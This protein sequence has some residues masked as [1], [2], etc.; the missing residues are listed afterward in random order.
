MKQ[1]RNK[2]IYA[3]LLAVLMLLG[4]VMGVYAEE[5]ITG[6]GDWLV[7]IGISEDSIDDYP[8]EDELVPQAATACEESGEAND[9]FDWT[10]HHA[11]IHLSISGYENRPIHGVFY[12]SA[13]NAVFSFKPSGAYKTVDRNNVILYYYHYPNAGIEYRSNVLQDGICETIIVQKNKSS[14]RAIT[15]YP[16]LSE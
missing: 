13:Y 10:G 2:R 12:E 9:A 1:F 16:T 4:S 8:V 6:V 3:I 11:N 7:D 5:L 14:G 15:A